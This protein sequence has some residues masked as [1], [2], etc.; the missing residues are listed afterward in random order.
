MLNNME[1]DTT[2]ANTPKG[3]GWDQTVKGIEETP[4]DL[5]QVI[6]QAIVDLLTW[7]LRERQEG[8]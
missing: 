1:T 7:R 3:R 8:Q 4:E 2:L 5:T 6:E